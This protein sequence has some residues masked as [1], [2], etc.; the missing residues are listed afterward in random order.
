MMLSLMV[1]LLVLSDALHQQLGG[2]SVASCW[3]IAA[4]SLA[5]INSILMQFN[6]AIDF[7]LVIQ[8]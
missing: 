7:A 1:T 8:C 2:I 3:I 6:S 4:S 5:A